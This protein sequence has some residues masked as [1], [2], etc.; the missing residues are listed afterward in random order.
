MASS[1][2]SSSTVSYTVGSSVS[3]SSSSSSPSSSTSSVSSS[4]SSSLQKIQELGLKIIINH[5]TAKA[6][7][8]SLSQEDLSKTSPIID[9]PGSKTTYHIPQ[10]NMQTKSVLHHSLL[11]IQMRESV[12]STKL[13]NAILSSYF[14]TGWI[15]DDFTSS[16]DR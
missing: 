6:N 2:T 5:A 3:T 15:D 8:V 10:K 12:L 11:S 13:I 7:C 16:L 14:P 4:S 1:I 9:F